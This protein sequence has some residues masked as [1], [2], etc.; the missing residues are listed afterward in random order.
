ML[1]TR[2]ES[3]SDS[4]AEAD[5]QAHIPPFPPEFGEDKGE[6]FKHYD[7]IQDELDEEMVKRL[8]ENLDGMLVFAGLFAGVNSAFLAFTLELVSPDPFDDISSLLQQIMEGLRSPTS[9]PSMSFT[10]PLKAILINALFILSLSSALFASFFAVLGKQWLMLYRNRNGGGV[11]QQRWEQLRRS[12]GAERWGLVPVLE[13]V[14]PVLVQTSVIIFAVGLVSFLGTTSGTLA[15]FV[16]VPLVVA[17]FLLVLFAGFS[18]WDVS[19]P[20][21][22]PI[23]EILLRT[24]LLAS[25][26]TRPFRRQKP[27]RGK[28]TLFLRFKTRLGNWWKCSRNGGMTRRE[29]GKGTGSGRYNATAEASGQVGSGVVVQ[30]VLSED[31]KG[32]GSGIR[33]IKDEESGQAGVSVAV[34]DISSPT[35]QT[36]DRPHRRREQWKSVVRTVVSSNRGAIEKS[37]TN[38]W[39]LIASLRALMSVLWESFWE[40]ELIRSIEDERVLQV[41]SIKRVINISEDL[42]AL[43][44]A[45][46]NLRSITDPELL[47]LVCDDESTARGLRE[48]YTESLEELNK[49]YSRD[50][51]N[52][53]LLRET[54]A[55][56]TA[57]FHA[58]ISVASFDD[59]IEM[60]GIKGFD[61]P[62]ESS[63][64][65]PRAAE[66]TGKNCRQAHSFIRHFIWLQM[67]GLGPQPTEL[68]STTLAAIALWYA[69]NGIPHSQDV[70][71]GSKFRDALVSSEMSWASL[72][73]LTFISNL[74][75][76]FYDADEMEPYQMEWLDWC[77]YAFVRVRKAY[78]MSKP[79]HELAV[80]IHTSLESDINFETNAIL[81]KFAWKLFTK[82][83][84]DHFAKLG[85]HALAAG[86]YFIC[87]LEREIRSMKAISSQEQEATSSSKEPSSPKAAGWKAASARKAAARLEIAREMCFTA[88]IECMGPR[89]GKVEYGYMFLG[90][91]T[92]KLTS[93]ML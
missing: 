65:S 73:L 28:K 61:L 10:P 83:D 14:L 88:M 54:L 67:R 62:L 11:D 20:F 85:Q 23:S 8:K 86:Q 49:K 87:S 9:L 24:P 55:F 29:E 38:F 75:C 76:R 81:F 80:A 44:H 32:L 16:L 47:V 64:M 21:R 52:P 71:Y 74:P 36:A 78:S 84:G 6:F 37:K 4:P 22:H 91:E 33:D 89:D 45:A 48:C 43:Y 77:R 41:E 27:T 79:T 70:I 12:M 30:N 82:D 46:L 5:P 90:L 34:Q 72:Q 66:L 7:K 58:S 56:G 35:F 59:F 93:W 92:F 3:P 15:I 68:T 13:V 60:L 69:I 31:Y 2:T 50:K 18:I 26:I 1:E 17:S 51:P 57:F 42:S 39:S 63:E 40:L 53:K 25:A 19:C